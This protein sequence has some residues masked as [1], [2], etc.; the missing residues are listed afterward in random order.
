VNDVGNGAS[1][2]SLARGALV[3][4]K[5]RVDHPLTQAVPARTVGARDVA[6]GRRVALKLLREGTRARPDLVTT[7]SQGARTVAQLESP[8]VGRVIDAGA[9]EDG[10]PFL[11]REY[12]EQDSL[13]H[14]PKAALD[15][16][17]AADYAI[18]ACEALAEAHSKGIVHGDLKP[19]NLFLIDRFPGRRS[20]KVVDFG[21]SAFAFANPSNVV[22]SATIGYMSPEQ[23]RSGSAA[24]HR[25]DVWSLGA[26]L[27]ELLTGRAAFDRA[28]T[29]AQ[30]VSAILDRP[31]ASPR[32]RRPEIPDDLALIVLR[33]LAKEPGAR[34]QSA[35]ELAMA[36]LAFA[37][38][39]ARAD[40]ERAASMAPAG[41]GSVAASGRWRERPAPI[42]A[43]PAPGEAPAAHREN[44]PSLA[45]V[46]RTLFGVG[47]MQKARGAARAPLSRTLFGIGQL[48]APKGR[49][50]SPSLPSTSRTGREFPPTPTPTKVGLGNMPTPMAMSAP[51]PLAP[52]GVDAEV[53]PELPRHA[54]PGWLGVA[55][56]SGAVVVV[57]AA[58]LFA[59]PEG[60]E[61]A[62]SAARRTA[63]AA[64]SGAAGSS[65]PAAPEVVAVIVRAS[66]PSAQIAVDGAPLE[67]NPSRALFPKGAEMHRI[68]ASAEGYDPQTREV[69]AAEDAVVSLSLRRRPAD[70]SRTVVGPSEPSI[71]P[72]PPSA[73]ARGTDPFKERGRPR[74]IETRDP[75]RV[76]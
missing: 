54:L 33:C 3:A 74:P 21:A 16:A 36:L 66:P 46:S 41:T 37:P 48:G 11:V 51:A 76:P 63:R 49:D 69:S 2:P 75:D 40:A 50:P 35:G 1:G 23:L 57:F 64:V 53:M 70:V 6:L 20:V 34:F 65:A 71:D 55:A 27:Y 68:V 17:S 61:R 38:Q 30:L 31:V 5:Y 43:R 9:T 7:F 47:E 18:Q 12:F 10:T 25:S 26:T 13:A 67:T 8:H 45:P 73:A 28:Q 59:A 72:E 44:G 19:D 58:I 52:E 32:D 14:R 39:E 62:R 29:L 24:D 4:G 42:D 22:T 15:V 60:T 56:M